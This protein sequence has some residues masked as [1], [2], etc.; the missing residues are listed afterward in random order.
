MLA[1][2]AGAGQA[3][4]PLR[5]IGLTK[6]IL[7]LGLNEDELHTFCLR[8]ARDLFATFHEDVKI[9]TARSAE[10]QTR[11]STAFTAL[12]DRASFGEFLREFGQE[13]SEDRRDEVLL[14][15]ALQSEKLISESLRTDNI[16]LT[17]ERDLAKA[18]QQNFGV[19]LRGMAAS[20]SFNMTEGWNDMASV[21]AN[22]EVA[23][24]EVFSENRKH[25][26]CEPSP[27]LTERFHKGCKILR[28]LDILRHEHVAK[29][30]TYK[31]SDGIIHSEKGETRSILGCVDPNGKGLVSVDRYLGTMKGSAF[32]TEI[33]LL[34]QL[35]P[36]IFAPS[37]LIVA[38]Q[39]KPYQII[40]KTSKEAAAEIA[41][42]V[43]K[44]RITLREK[45]S[46]MK[47]LPLYLLLGFRQINKAGVR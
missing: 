32:F 7:E 8:R 35:R 41:F 42:K 38:L 23:V 20:L 39:S 33:N 10:L 36:F 17:E 21:T 43:T 19:Y 24:L 40:A 1:H 3:E 30:S 31:I 37:F 15:Q 26:K 5:A 2:F 22:G 14:R 6:E 25:K 4:N 47:F 11:Y 28:D 9:K 27:D 46:E 18:I 12:K 45:I 13:R 29:V 16:K 44:P 34:T